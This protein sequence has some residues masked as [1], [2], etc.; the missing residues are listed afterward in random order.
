MIDLDAVWAAR[1]ERRAKARAAQA[2]KQVSLLS[3]RPPS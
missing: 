3:E 2:E 1:D